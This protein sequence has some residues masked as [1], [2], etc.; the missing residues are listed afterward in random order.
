MS[1]TEETL[2]IE[3]I[4]DDTKA[5]VRPSLLQTLDWHYLILIAIIITLLYKWI[6]YL[7]LTYHIM[8]FWGFGVLGF[9]GSVGGGTGIDSF[10]KFEVFLSV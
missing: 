3:S 1:K 8:G 4:T 2:E 7:N 9:W 6:Q 5:S 10:A